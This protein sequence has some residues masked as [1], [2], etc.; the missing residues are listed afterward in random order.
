M[1]KTKKCKNCGESNS[2]KA[3]FCH[4][5]GKELID[6]KIKNKCPACKALNSHKAKFCHICGEEI[7]KKQQIHTETHTET[8]SHRPIF[9]FA[10]H[11][12]FS[13]GIL[14]ALSFLVL[15]IFFVIGYI[16][17]SIAVTLRGKDKPPSWEG[18]ENILKYGVGGLF[19]IMVYLSIP[20]LILYLGIINKSIH[21]QFIAIIFMIII[22]VL[23]PISWILYIKNARF[24][25][26]FKFDELLKILKKSPG[27]YF[28]AYFLILLYGILFSVF[29]TLSYQSLTTLFGGIF[30]LVYN[31][32]LQGLGTFFLFLSL[33]R[34]YA[35]I[36]TENYIEKKKEEDLKKW[37][38]L[39]K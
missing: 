15:P 21:L 28:I 30:G 26:A 17:K 11:K 36:Y 10:I 18:L 27:S 14:S 22:G 31:L 23:I 37:Q 8:K 39:F 6:E 16:M 32:L 38:E 12:I 25:S 7:A 24:S 4:I 35:V 29:S 5:C 34:Y 19:I 33:A 9:S 2:D 20:A 1:K 13:G 3:K